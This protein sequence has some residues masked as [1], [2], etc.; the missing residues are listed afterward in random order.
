MNNPSTIRHS[1]RV[2]SLI[3]TLLISLVLGGLLLTR[4]LSWLDSWF[5]PEDEI[6]FSGEDPILVDIKAP[7][8]I[9]PNWETTFQHASEA[10][11]TIPPTTER[12]TSLSPSTKSPTTTAP[13]TTS[14]TVAKT[15]VP[16]T[17]NTFVFRNLSG[18][19]TLA[20]T[21][22][23]VTLQPTIDP[24]TACLNNKKI[25]MVNTFEFGKWNCSAPILDEENHT[26]PHIYEL[27]DVPPGA[28]EN[29]TGIMLIVGSWGQLC[30]KI[31]MIAGAMRAT[32]NTSILAL[33]PS[34]AQAA[35]TLD[36]KK[37]SSRNRAILMDCELCG[38]ELYMRCGH[39]IIQGKIY[40]VHERVFKGTWRLR[41]VQLF[42]GARPSA[43]GYYKE[44]VENIQPMPYLKKLI[45]YYYETQFRPSIP[46]N[47]KSIGMHRRFMDNLCYQYAKDKG[48]YNCRLQQNTVQQINGYARAV[49]RGEF[50]QSFLKS[51]Q[52][53]DIDSNLTRLE[54][55][56]PIVVSCNYTLEKAQRDIINRTWNV[57]EHYPFK[58][59]LADD[60]QTPRGRKQL[61]DSL[62][63]LNS[64]NAFEFDTMDNPT[65]FA[66]RKYHSMLA[67]MIAL[68]MT[69]Y[70]MGT[71]VSSCDDIIALWRIGKGKAAGSSYPGFCYDAY[72]QDAQAKGALPG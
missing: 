23:P 42:A 19:K 18:E 56:Y 39:A 11:T 59:V 7:T 72:Y 60:K 50:Q 28:L 24:E 12:P 4:E 31:T 1:G 46:E 10:P 30:N 26:T 20:P 2:T 34:F 3:G 68:S 16:N 29:H 65:C 5:V 58:L 51:R 8:K 27:K 62:E 25:R 70:H 55:K 38:D 22:A 36:L 54:D 45:E 44:I 66:K 67:E 41:A 48:Q 37:F 9:A 52:F 57:L 14:P 15:A 6:N 32:S 13:T 47:F 35:W 53:I 69:D 71:M 21:R 64:G 43:I 61:F 49:E 63:E 33:Q 40:Q 17:A